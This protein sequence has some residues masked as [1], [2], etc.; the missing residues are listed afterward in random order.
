MH[1]IPAWYPLFNSELGIAS[2]AD[3]LVPYPWF[4]NLIK[5]WCA[6]A[7]MDVYTRNMADNAEGLSSF[8]SQYADS[9][10]VH[11]FSAPK[12]WDQIVSILHIIA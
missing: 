10:Q 3:S 9:P 11:I 6:A 2:M 4:C 8:P 5:P 7:V 1:N 12:I